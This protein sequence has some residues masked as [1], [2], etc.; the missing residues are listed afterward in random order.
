M[1][2]RILK[3]VGGL[4]QVYG[5]DGIIPCRPRGKF[6]KNRISPIPGDIVEYSMSS[7]EGVIE[8]ILTRSNELIRPLVANIT[9]AFT[10]FAIKDPDLNL[11]LLF[12]YLTELER[13][14]IRPLIVLNKKD[15][16]TDEEKENLRKI[17]DLIPYEYMI[18]STDDEKDVEDLKKRLDGEVTI[19]CGPSGAGKSTLTNM[20]F[21]EEKME[22]GSV[23]EKIGRGKNTTKH[24][25]LIKI[26]GGFIADTPGFSVMDLKISDHRE[27][28]DLF[29]EFSKFDDV[30]AFNGCLHYREPV[31]SVRES[32]DKGL[33]S[34]ERYDFYVSMLEK[35][36]EG[37]KYRWK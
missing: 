32:A 13:N 15:K 22:T 4:Y 23:S 17:F 10:V 35:I 28:K 2:G 16:V 5:E 24:T 29:P 34:R 12:T 9:Q 19:L 1:K 25:E 7:D 37:E 3:G 21:G 20:I 30:C 26:N 8:D 31:C 18:V 11:Y 27:L 33:I 6:R 14:G 36:K